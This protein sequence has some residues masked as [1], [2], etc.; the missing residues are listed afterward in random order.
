MKTLLLRADEAD[1]LCDPP[2]RDWLAERGFTR[3]AYE[4]LLFHKLSS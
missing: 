2:V 3:A 4:R 1:M